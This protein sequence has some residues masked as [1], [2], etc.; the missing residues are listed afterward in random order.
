MLT[1][2]GVSVILV[3]GAG[4]GQHGAYSCDVS[5][6]KDGSSIPSGLDQRT[7]FAGRDAKSWNGTP[8][9]M[10]VKKD[11]YLKDAQ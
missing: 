3:I 8:V 5:W 10:G 1:S 7:A 6:L 4:H 9:G 11:Y 2:L